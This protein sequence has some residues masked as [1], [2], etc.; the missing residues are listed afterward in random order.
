MRSLHLLE[1]SLSGAPLGFHG[2]LL[3]GALSSEVHKDTND[4]NVCALD[5]CLRV[6]LG[7]QVKVREM[8]YRVET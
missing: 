3:S 7:G 1:A 6:A 4:L 2:A 5:D 8:G